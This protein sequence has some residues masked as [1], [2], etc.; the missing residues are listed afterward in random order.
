MKNTVADLPGWIFEAEETSANVYEVRGHDISGR[1]VS[2]KGVEVEDLL[3][4]A[5][6]EAR[7]LGRHHSEPANRSP[8]EVVVRRSIAAALD[9]PELADAAEV[10]YSLIEA[11]E[12]LG[13]GYSPG[14]GQQ[15]AWVSVLYD[16]RKESMLAAGFLGIDA[17]LARLRGAADVPVKLANVDMSIIMWLR[18]DVDC[19]VALF[20][21]RA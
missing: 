9:C 2:A 11:G 1:K 8:A 6:A 3:E 19:P 14:A 17:S 13:F 5:H 16:M 15:A 18:D 12:G 4:L 7:L 21:R 20:V 10:A